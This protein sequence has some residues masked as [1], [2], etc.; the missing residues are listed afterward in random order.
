M[1]LRR[2]GARAFLT[3][4]AGAGR[5]RAEQELELDDDRFAAL[6]PLTEGR[7]VVKRRYLIPAGGAGLT[8]EVD[9]YE[10][11]LA[12]LVVAEVEFPNEA[13]ADAFDAPAW[14]G[15]E[16]TGDARWSN[17]ALALHGRPE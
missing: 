4:K 12:G 11:R 1:R 7:R 15:R 6:W 3:I 8:A 16:V 14:L 9:V 5:S 2:R 17:R 10:Q 13:A